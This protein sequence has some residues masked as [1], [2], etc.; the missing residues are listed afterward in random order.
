M[1][2]VIFGLAVSSSWGNSP[3]IIWRG[4]CGAL[5][6]GGQCVTFFERDVSVYRTHRDLHNPAEYKLRL[7]ESWE[8]VECEIRK[9]LAETDCTIV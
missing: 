9:K 8:E 5:G 2:F 3:A 6:R 7:Y 1:R 4:L